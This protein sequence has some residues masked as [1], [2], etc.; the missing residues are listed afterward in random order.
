MAEYKKEIAAGSVLALAV[1]IILASAVLYLPLGLGQT[2]SL[3]ST[4]S[5]GQSGENGPA[6]ISLGSLPYLT[7]SPQNRTFSVPLEVRASVPVSL[8]YDAAGSYDSGGSYAVLFS[9]GTVWMYSENCFSGI[10]GTSSGG[11]PA[12]T[13]ICSFAADNYLPEN[14]AITNL[15]VNLSASGTW[16][17]LNPTT[18]PS[19]FNGN[20]T[21]TIHIGLPPGVYSLY[22]ALD[23]AMNGGTPGS[24]A[25]APA[26]LVVLKG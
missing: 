8:G 6:K 25:L 16:V 5:S 9:N 19:G 7:V 3:S 17:T 15:S 14:G 22:L 1:V 24:W 2:T 4:S 21:L 23:V 26:P 12:G 20:I 11:W 18:L 10:N 13:D